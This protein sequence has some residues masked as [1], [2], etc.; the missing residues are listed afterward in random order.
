MRSTVILGLHAHGRRL[1]GER[2]ETIRQLEDKAVEWV[3]VL[4]PGMRSAFTA[5]ACGLVANMP[6]GK[7]S[8]TVLVPRM[9]PPSFGARIDGSASS[10][11]CSASIF[12]SL[13]RLETLTSHVRLT[14]ALLYAVMN[15][16]IRVDRVAIRQLPLG[17]PESPIPLEH[18]KISLI[19]AHRGKVR[20]L[21]CALSYIAKAARPEMTVR[22]G[23]D[24]DN[25]GAYERLVAKYPLAQFFRVS[26]PAAGPYVIRQLLAG[27]GRAPLLA[28]HDSDDISCFDR[29]TALSREMDAT[30]CDLL[31]CHELRVDE[32]NQEV[33]ILRF[34]LDVSGSLREGPVHS[35]LHP[36]SIVRREAFFE[37]G[38]FSTDR[39]IA[40]DTQ[41]LLRACFNS[42]I[43][44]VD[45]FHYIRRKHAGALTVAPATGLDHPLRAELAQMW[46]RDF[47][48]VMQGR[49][50]LAESSL[51]AIPA[52]RKHRLIRIS[53]PENGHA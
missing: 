22:I 3:A 51:R 46:H 4:D 52:D 23:L 28:F 33:T 39:A 34:P 40:N 48:E 19:M 5:A 47:I 14:F 12:H 30:G 9:E 8:V 45:G 31:G 35:M 21:A 27:R 37:T 41:F 24:M 16:Q 25:A 7:R 10:F 6:R 20:H 50:P 43:R 13:M 38:G 26:S 2:I 44:N 15:N 1:R 42:R 11:I 53:L 36:S 18:R 49:M 17:E 32:L 29:F